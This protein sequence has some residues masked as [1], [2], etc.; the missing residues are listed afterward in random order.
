M[1]VTDSATSPQTTTGT[2]NLTVAVGILQSLGWAV[3]T[4]GD[5]LEALAAHERRHFDVIF[6]DRCAVELNV[7]IADNTN[8]LLPIFNQGH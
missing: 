7:G 3:E 6:M 8:L 1:R 4:A 5:G 2:I